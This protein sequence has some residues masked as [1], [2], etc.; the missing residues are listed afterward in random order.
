M[1]RR[2]AN[3][4]IEDTLLRHAE[5]RYDKQLLR[6]AYLMSLLTLLR[7]CL[8]IIAATRCVA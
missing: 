7:C 2:R 6:A 3:S 8:M 4:A 1:P 5:R